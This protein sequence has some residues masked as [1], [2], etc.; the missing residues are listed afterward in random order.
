MLA[1]IFLVTLFGL[2]SYSLFIDPIREHEAAVLIAT[3]ALAMALQEIMLL[4]FSGDY[5]SVPSL[6]G[7]IP[8]DFR[9]EGLLSTDC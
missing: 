1:A 4:L 7:G 8:D 9:G 3:I 6:I 5:L 2:L